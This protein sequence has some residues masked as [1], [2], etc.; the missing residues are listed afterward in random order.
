[1]RKKLI[2]KKDLKR[3]DKAFDWKYFTGATLG[4]G[5]SMIASILPFGKFFTGLILVFVLSPALALFWDLIEKKVDAFKD[6]VQEQVE[7]AKN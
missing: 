7:E 2:R 1:M 5:V 3:I 6:E 4:A